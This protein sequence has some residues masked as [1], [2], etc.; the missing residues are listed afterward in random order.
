MV[1]LVGNGGGQSLEAVRRRDCVLCP[2]ASLTGASMTSQA[3]VLDVQDARV[4]VPRGAA[5]FSAVVGESW[6]LPVAPVLSGP[7]TAHTAS[8]RGANAGLRALHAGFVQDEVAASGM[9]VAHDAVDPLRSRATRRLVAGGDD[10][11]GKGHVAIGRH[12]AGG[13]VFDRA[14]APAATGWL[15]VGAC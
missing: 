6:P 2:A 1:R 10:H 9:Y 5:V 4:I 7:S 14:D 3:A 13:V 8:T 11:G 15:G 12:G